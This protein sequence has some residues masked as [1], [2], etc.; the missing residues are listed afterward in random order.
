MVFIGCIENYSPGEDE[1]NIGTMVVTAHLTDKPGI[2]T[3]QLSR[4]V[5][6]SN[7]NFDPLSACYV[8]VKRADGEY[9]IFGETDPGY[10]S[11]DLDASFLKSGGEYQLIIVNSEGK[12]YESEYETLHPAAEIYDLYYELEDIP[13]AEAEI[14]DHGI[15]FFVDFEIEKDSGRYLRWELEE[16]FEIL[17]PDYPTRMYGVDRMWYDITSEQKRLKCWINN[18]ITEIYTLDLKNFAAESYRKYPLTFV[19]GSTWKLHRT[20]SLLLIQYSLSK[21][22]FWYWSE[23]AKNVQSKGGLFDTQ[24]ALTPS[25]VCN[26]GDENESVL[27]YFSISGISEKRIFVGTVQG[28]EIFRNPNFCRPGLFPMFLHRYPLDKLPLYVARALV[29]GVNE[30]GKVKYECVDCSLYKNSLLEKPEYWQD[31]CNE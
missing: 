15:R 5:S 2:Q 19:S 12:R 6:I 16:T 22:A 8:E 21:N 26:V 31:Y 4:S 27:G 24:P 10:Y 29:M 11:Q 9:R 7:S 1:L 20:Y 28:L 30:N 18:D 25:N 14:T 13:T 3:V 23:L 17:N